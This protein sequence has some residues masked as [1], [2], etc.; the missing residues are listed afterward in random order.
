MKSVTL[1]IVIIS[2]VVASAQL[3]AQS[4]STANHSPSIAVSLALEQSQVPVGNTPRAV[5]TVK[6][7]ADQAICFSTSMH[8]YRIHVSSKTGEAPETELRRHRHGDFRPG[9]KPELAE[10]PVVC[11]EIAPGKSVIRIYDLS[12]FYDLSVPGAYT[13]Y[14]EVRD[15]SGVWLRSNT[16]KLEMTAVAQ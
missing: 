11:P 6:N 7:V 8:L 13:V 4:A 5:L 16:A 12:K 2:T 15:T 3:S 10:G 9:D 1:S 14:I